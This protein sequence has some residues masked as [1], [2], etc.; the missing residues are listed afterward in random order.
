M[1][2][3]I[4]LAERGLAPDTLIRAG[5]K[6][7]LRDRIKECEGK[8]VENSWDLS[9]RFFDAMDKA[10]L[11]LHTPDANTQHYEVPTEFYELCL[12]GRKK[13]SSCYFPTG[14]ETLDEAEE[15]MLAKTCE[16]AALQDGQDVLELGCGWGSLSLWMAEKYPKSKITAVSN[17][18]TQR[19][20]IEKVANAKGFKNLTVITCDM[21]DF[22]IDR[23]FDRVVS[24]EMFEHMRNWRLL[25]QKVS[26]WLKPDGKLFFH[27]FVH[28]FYTYPFETEG[29]DN[30]MGRHFFTGGIMPAFDLPLRFQE[31]LKIDSQW[32][33]DGQHYGQTAEW[34]LKNLDRN[35]HKAL[36]VF[37]KNPRPDG[38]SSV[39][40]LNRWRIFFMACAELWNF[41]NGREWCVG[42]YLFSRRK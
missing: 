37:E 10:P 33:V 40:M 15:I 21:N 28:R 9:C 2:S 27:I 42:H 12:G 31:H 24:V 5:I 22:A 20:F 34:W 32:L 23:T 8:S 29:D 26:N 39:V 17:S 7:L 25:F 19:E 13:Y 35:R 3:G 38:A 11:A 1:I 16:R 14:R 18:R 30:W 36:A 6:R 41:E 4:D